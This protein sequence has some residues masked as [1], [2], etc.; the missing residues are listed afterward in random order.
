LYES[1][2]FLS[3]SGNGAKAKAGSPIEVIQ[4]SC[5]GF[6][7]PIRCASEITRLDS[8]LFASGD[9]MLEP[10]V[11][12]DFESILQINQAA[13]PGVLSLS[14]PEPERIKNEAAVFCAL[15]ANGKCR[16]YVIAYSRDSTYDGE[17]F[18]WLQ[19]NVTDKFL[20][21]DQIAV[22]SE[23]HGGGFGTRVCEFMERF[24]VMND[25]TCLCCEVNLKP[26]NPQ[27]ERFHLRRE[28]REI[29]RLETADGRI[30]AVMK[31]DLHT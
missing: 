23:S 17:E 30:V 3:R 8:Q 31:K 10:V 19:K 11:N 14:L 1:R 5:G 15:K 25:F 22:A 6:V 12:A 20:Y 16:A 24:A 21:I 7:N 28:F 26:P 2:G 29:G 4:F 27:S 18:R 9:I 13:Q